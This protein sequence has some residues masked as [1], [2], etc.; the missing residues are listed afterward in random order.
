MNIAFT[1]D[2]SGFG[3]GE[4][5]LLNLIDNLPKTNN[6]VVLFCNS[7]GDLVKCLSEKGF[8]TYIINFLCKKR[9]IRNIIEIRKVL[10]NQKIEIVHSNG[11]L[12]SILFYIAGF[13]I[14]KGNYW[15][16]HGQWYVL[17][18]LTSNALK[19]CNKTIFCVSK[20]CEV[21]LQSMG[22]KNTIVS[23]LG[24]PSN[25]YHYSEKGRLR[26]EYDIDD[27]IFVIAT[28]ARFQKI[29]GQ[30]K[31]VKAVERLIK[32]HKKIKYLLVGDNVFCSSVDEQYKMSV[33]DYIRNAK[34]ENDILVIGE[35]KDIKNI[36]KEI[37][38]L[39]IPSDNE[40]FGMVAAEALA[41]ETPIIST[42][43]DGVSEILE[44]NPLMI[45]EKN[46]DESLY[47]SMKKYIDDEQVRQRI[48]EFEHERWNKYDI[49]KI[50]KIYLERFGE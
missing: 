9:V 14:I 43:N 28:I 47:L 15:T 11:M 36:Y 19:I 35:R 18:R 48:K 27:E 7:N 5:F 32:D 6:K 39:L 1:S 13:G 50:T 37:D 8:G 25:I 10:K 16:C 23:N 21:N 29:K 42:P 4:T 34:L 3:G 31:G 17:N 49:E 12:T 2:L 44:N 24:I 38:L 46:D 20:A 30:L 26:S 40:S 45:S 41:A 22:V 33:I